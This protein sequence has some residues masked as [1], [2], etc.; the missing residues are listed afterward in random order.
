MKPYS[1]SIAM[2]DRWF[3]GNEVTTGTQKEKQSKTQTYK[4][5]RTGETR[6]NKQRPRTR[7]GE[8]VQIARRRHIRDSEVEKTSQGCG[9]Y[10]GG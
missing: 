8:P 1:Q 5:D 2:G 9:E 3:G 10:N 7:V 4:Y 6:R